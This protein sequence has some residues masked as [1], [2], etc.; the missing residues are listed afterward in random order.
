MSFFVKP[1]R[2]VTAAALL[3]GLQIP[4]A[5]A[6]NDAVCRDYATAAIRQ[7][8]LMHEHPACNRGQGPRWNDDWNVHYSWCRQVSFHDMAIERDAR[9]NWLHSCGG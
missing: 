6:E 4:S 3:L 9:T 2:A 5:F 8:H 1:V 7:V